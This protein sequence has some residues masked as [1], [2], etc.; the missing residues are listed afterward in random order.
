M[1]YMPLVN[2]FVVTEIEALNILSDVETTHIASGGVNGSEGAVTLV[3]E[4]TENQI[5]KGFKVV[6]G[7]KGELKVSHRKL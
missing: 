2:S 3:M 4:G 7:V 6:K 1:G 5:N